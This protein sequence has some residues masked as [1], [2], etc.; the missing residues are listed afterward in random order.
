MYCLV[1][2]YYTSP[3]LMSVI[4]TLA[5]TGVI[6]QM[7]ISQTI[8]NKH[9]TRPFNSIARKIALFKV[10]VIRANKLLLLREMYN[11]L[12]LPVFFF[13]VFLPVLSKI[14]GNLAPPQNL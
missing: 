7:C 11:A 2:P 1:G 5:L 10:G 3:K 4:S 14:L 6:F 9:H 13:F 8:I 12:Q